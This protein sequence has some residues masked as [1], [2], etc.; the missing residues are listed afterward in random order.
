MK[1]KLSSFAL[2]KKQTKGLECLNCGQPFRGNENFC[3][4]CGQK[5]TTKRLSF[6][7]FINNVFSGFISYDS[8]FWN[9]FIPLLIKPGKVSKDYIAGKRA[10]F[11]NPFQLYL[12]VSIIFFLILGISNKID[13][14]SIPVN[15]I[16]NA[17]ETIDSLKQT[18]QHKIDSIIKST[19]NEIKKE[20][21]NDTTATKAISSIANFLTL[22][23]NISSKRVATP[24]Q[25]H[26]KTDTTKK[27]S[28]WYKIQDFYNYNKVKPH[29]SNKVALDSLGY[30]KTFWNSFYYQQIINSNKNFEQLKKDGGKTYFKKISS[31]LSIS[32]FIFL[33]VFTLFLLLIYWRKKNTYIEHLVV[34]FN[35]QTVFFLLLSIFYLMDFVINIDNFSGIFTL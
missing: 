20:S 22:N 29:L 27:I 24:Y 18:N 28:V 6:S 13:N 33:P 11:V 16:V 17:P 30:K 9:T 31:V 14:F 10:R 26:I 23:E 4:S 1:F 5:N 19:Q 15:D 25:Y 7:L 3:S 21:P 35:T 34:V 12:N 8:R 2:K 32:L